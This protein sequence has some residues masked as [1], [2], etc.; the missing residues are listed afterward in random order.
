[1]NVAVPGD[2]SCVD[3]AAAEALTAGLLKFTQIRPKPPGTPPEAANATN[4]TGFCA[5]TAAWLDHNVEPA[6]AGHRHT[7][8]AGQEMPRRPDMPRNQETKRPTK[9]ENETREQPILERSYGSIGIPAVAAAA[10]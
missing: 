1:M 8:A 9:G 7:T 2:P 6:S 4:P 5:E 10:R 3:H